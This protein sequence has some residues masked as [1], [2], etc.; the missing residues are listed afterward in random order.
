MNLFTRNAFRALLCLSTL[1]VYAQKAIIPKLSIINLVKDCG[2]RPNDAINDHKAFQKAADMINKKKRNVTLVIPAGTYIVGNQ[3]TSMKPNTIRRFGTNLL[4]LISCKNIQIMGVGK[5]VIKYADALTFGSF[6]PVTQKKYVHTGGA[7]YNLDYANTVGECIYIRK[8]DNI[9]VD[10]IELNGNNGKLIVGGYFGDTGIQ[11]PHDGIVVEDSRNIN[12]QRIFAH[13]FGRDGIM[14]NNATPAG[15]AT[16]DQQIKIQQSQFDYNCRQGLS[17][18]S[19]VGLQALNCSFSFT[20]QSVMASS[21]AAGID[22]EAES[23]VVRNGRFT[24]CSMID[25]IGCG[26]VASSGDSKNM[27]FDQCTFWGVKTW[28][29]WTSKPAFTYKNSS[30]YGSTVWGCDATNEK[31]A[32]RFINCR[33]EDKPYKGKPVFGNFLVEINTT[34][35]QTFQH[36][37]F[38]S[39]NRKPMWMDGS[40]VWKEDEFIRVEDCEFNINYFGYPANDYIGIMRVCNISG[41]KFNFNIKKQDL[42]GRQIQFTHSKLSADNVF[43]YLP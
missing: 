11:L 7:F 27:L 3:I 38:T 6:D 34:K 15:E 25:N 37:T 12:I 9:R 21:P 4:E 28:S 39:N 36:C 2:A 29:N 23:G 19:G 41:S 5:V 26:M 1:N 30:F 33:F 8:C 20:G 42:K 31:D 40:P 24:S 35:R 32:T 10:N 22:I 18:V 14:V 43:I 17:W 13:H 16:P